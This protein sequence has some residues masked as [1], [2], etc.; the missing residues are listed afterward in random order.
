MDLADLKTFEAVA[1]HGS[2]NKAAAELH[3]VQSNVTARIRALEEELGLPLFQRHA[4]GVALTPAGQRVLPY[5]GRV[6]KLLAEAGAAARDD[7]QPCGTLTL[8]GLET[9]T[10]LR[11]SPALTAY[12]RAYPD[13]R[14]VMSTGTTAQ[15]VQDVI[16]YRYDGVFVAGPVKHPDLEA[17][18][19]FVEELV[20]VAHPDLASLKDL[21]GLADLRTIVFHAG[22]SYR[23]RLEAYLGEKGIVATQPLEFG[24]L[25]TIVSCVSAGVGVTMLPR[26]VVAEA[27]RLGRV[28]LHDLPAPKARVDTQFVRRRDAYVSSALSAFLETLRSFHKRPV[29]A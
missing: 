24:S 17:T 5:A 3:T 25:D 21:P 14:L 16:D 13:V 6:S 29:A 2:M 26:V 18:T 10:A 15:L 23:Q 19:I 20:L 1:R 7:G 27:A 12:A 9:T 22:C 4:R 28:S 8:G 11:L